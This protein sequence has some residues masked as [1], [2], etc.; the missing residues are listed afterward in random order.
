MGT[1]P[2][3]TPYLQRVHSSDSENQWSRWPLRNILTRGGVE[4]MSRAHPVSSLHKS[5]SHGEV[6][7][8][9]SLGNLDVQ[10]DILRL[11]GGVHHFGLDDGVSHA[12]SNSGLDFIAIK[13]HWISLVLQSA[14]KHRGTQSK[15]T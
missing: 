4:S 7:D 13:S 14:R 3:M 12:R 6:G 15:I 2:T 11:W 9:G 5:H 8:E 10:H 1:Q